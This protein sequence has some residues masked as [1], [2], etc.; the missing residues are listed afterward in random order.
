MLDELFRTQRF[1]RADRRGTHGGKARAESMLQK[2]KLQGR[3][4]GFVDPLVSLL[5]GSDVVVTK[6]GGLTTAGFY[7]RSYYALCRAAFHEYPRPLRGE[8]FSVDTE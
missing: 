6:P 1:G 5:R 2:L 4:L 7:D 8:Q 3:V